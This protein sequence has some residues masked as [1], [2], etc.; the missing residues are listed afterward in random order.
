MA[1][2]GY[3]S[4]PVNVNKIPTKLYEYTAAELPYLVEKGSHWA[5]V[6]GELG[7]A[8]PIDFGK[9]TKQIMAQIDKIKVLGF[10]ES[11]FKWEEQEA[12]LQEFI[13]NIIS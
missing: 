4:N 5:L 2:I 13:E 1:I 3:A 12:Q 11:G 6:G 9:P 8:I 10:A 7:G